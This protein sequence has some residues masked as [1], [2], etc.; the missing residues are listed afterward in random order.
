MS[1]EDEEHTRADMLSPGPPTH[2]PQ[3]V[4]KYM[5][6]MRLLCDFWKDEVDRENLYNFE[7]D[8]ELIFLCMR[9]VMFCVFIF[10]YI[11]DCV[12]TFRIFNP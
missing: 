6:D 4:E 2:V 9:A 8:G 10:V 5:G 1:L 7:K 3:P 12:E 11:S